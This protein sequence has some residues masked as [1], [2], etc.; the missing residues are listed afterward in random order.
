MV[1]EEDL[2]ALGED[3]DMVTPETPISVSH[4]ANRTT[5]MVITSALLNP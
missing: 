5:L 4:P 3:F 1:P 2:L